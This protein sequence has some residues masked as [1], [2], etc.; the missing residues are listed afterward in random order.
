MPTCVICTSKFDGYGNKPAPVKTSGVCCDSCSEV[1]LCARLVQM[2]HTEYGA[3]L[4]VRRMKAGYAWYH[5]KASGV[6]SH[7]RY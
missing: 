6:P 2:G 3:R 7:L 1:V 5:G 4:D